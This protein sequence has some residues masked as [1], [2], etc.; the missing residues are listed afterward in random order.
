MPIDRG[1]LDQQLEALGGSV[2][3]WN[4]RELRDLPAIL[5]ADEEVV[6]IARGKL[7]RIRFMRRSRLI[8]VTDRR[9]VCIRSGRKAGWTQFE[10]RA[11]QIRRA[12]LRI[13]LFRGRVI[14]QTMAGTWR[15]LLPRNDAYDVSR[16]ITALVDAPQRL[17]GNR[18]RHVVRRVIDH[19]LA[20]PAV[21]L[22]PEAP[23]RAVP[24]AP[25]VAPVPDTVRDRME[26][27]EDETEELRRQV[28][29]LEQLIR[30][31]QDEVEG[32]R[33]LRIGAGVGI[34]ASSDPHP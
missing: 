29:F 5:E 7:G 1:T 32:S 30:G 3:W 9:L 15:L 19:I 20:F 13:G 33:S 25:A 6:A 8:V 21:A 16:A 22:E 14:V 11:E 23:T 17:N 10:L 12:A 18:P 27:L 28:A 34:E 31:R 2:R 26:S 24:Q 4:E